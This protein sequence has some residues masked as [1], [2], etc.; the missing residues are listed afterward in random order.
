MVE[1]SL[2]LKRL[3]DQKVLARKKNVCERERGSHCTN[4]ACDQTSKRRVA[5]W[6]TR[7]FSPVRKPFESSTRRAI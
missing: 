2:P 1:S 3:N 7:P 4:P 6:T 5:E